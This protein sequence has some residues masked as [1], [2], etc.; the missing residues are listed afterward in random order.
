[1]KINVHEFQELGEKGLKFECFGGWDD[2]ETISNIIENE[3]NAVRIEKIDGVYTR[4]WWYKW[5]NLIFGLHYHEDIGNYI[6]RTDVE[7]IKNLNIIRKN[8][9]ALKILDQNQL[10]NDES[11]YQ[12]LYK[13]ALEVTNALN[14][15]MP[16]P[17]KEYTINQ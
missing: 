14:K 9:E 15:D 6:R 12:G 17:G 3:I 7:E 2:F 8:K 5:E 11:T 1:M 13:L 4:V 16:P 10:I